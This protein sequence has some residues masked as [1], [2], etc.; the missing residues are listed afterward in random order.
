LVDEGFDL[1]VRIGEQAD[2]GSLVARRLGEHGMLL[3]ASP[4]YLRRSGEPSAVDALSRHQA[5]GYLH[6]GAVLPW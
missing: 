6:A 5:V 2:S 1:A 4:D 3:C